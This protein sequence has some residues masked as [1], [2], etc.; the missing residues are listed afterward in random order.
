MELLV[1][2]DGSALHKNIK[3]DRTALQLFYRAES[4]T[5]PQIPPK[6]P[7]YTDSRQ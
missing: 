1:F 4:R 3:E 5:E 6:H 7:L 2:I